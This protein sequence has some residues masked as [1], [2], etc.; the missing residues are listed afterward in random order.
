MQRSSHIFGR[1]YSR[2]VSSLTSFHSSFLLSTFFPSL[3]PSL[4]LLSFLPFPFFLIFLPLSINKSFLD[5][6]ENYAFLT[7][8]LMSQQKRGGRREEIRKDFLSEKDKMIA[9]NSTGGVQVFLL[10]SILPLGLRAWK[11]LWTEE[12]RRLQSMGS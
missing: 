7:P 10:C 5:I 11:I 6:S 8:F 1:Q 9:L 4:P 12:P 3:L 2:N